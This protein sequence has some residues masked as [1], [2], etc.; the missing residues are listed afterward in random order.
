MTSNLNDFKEFYC[1]VCIK[2][3][4]HYVSGTGLVPVFRLP[5]SRYL[6]CQILRHT[7]E[8]VHK[9]MNSDCNKSLIISDLETCVGNNTNITDYKHKNQ[10]L[11]SKLICLCFYFTNSRNGYMIRVLWLV[12]HQAHLYKIQ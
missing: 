5:F 3:L 6:I 9:V 4:S 10:L 12:H 1:T 8:K 7:I 11:E 2:N